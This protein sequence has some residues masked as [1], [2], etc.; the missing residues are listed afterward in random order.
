[1]D[2]TSKN[3]NEPG[4]KINRLNNSINKMLDCV[5]YL[6]KM[7]SSNNIISSISDEE[8]EKVINYMKQV[9][10]SIEEISKPKKKSS[11]TLYKAVGKDKNYW[12]SKEPQNKSA[13]QEKGFKTNPILKDNTARSYHKEAKERTRSLLFKDKDF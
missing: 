11:E 7:R 2:N 4:K 1:M 12:V 6:E 9:E 5:K 8:L 13:A 10:K 3:T